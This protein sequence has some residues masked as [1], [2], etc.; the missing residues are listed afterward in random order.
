[1][2]GHDFNSWG[3]ETR[4]G[5]I[6]PLWRSRWNGNFL[7]HT[8]D[9]L[10]VNAQKN[11]TQQ[12]LVRCARS[13]FSAHPNVPLL[14]PCRPL[15]ND[16]LGVKLGLQP[17]DLAGH[18]RAGVCVCVCVRVCVRVC[19]FAFV[20]VCVC[21]CVCVRVCVC[22]C[23]CGRARACVF[24]CVCCVC[25]RAYVCVCVCVRSARAAAPRARR[26]ALRAPLR[27]ARAAVLRARI[28]S[29]RWLRC[30]ARRA[31]VRSSPT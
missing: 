30:H 24:V 19:A 15:W 10:M 26:S 16:C 17:Q 23:V 25:A 21:A 3:M 27:S 14:T 11:R 4:R 29:E 9:Y 31:T 7:Q 20:C 8:Q 2:L 6:P 18:S 1:M 12:L 28:Q 13:A 22:V 5:S